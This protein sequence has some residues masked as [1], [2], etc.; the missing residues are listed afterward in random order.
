MTGEE[1]VGLVFIV[2]WALSVLASL[3]MSAAVVYVLIHFLSK[4]W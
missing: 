3:A 2:M 4:Y 1:K